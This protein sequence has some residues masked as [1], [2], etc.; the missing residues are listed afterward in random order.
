[1]PAICQQNGGG[2]KVGG[3]TFNVSIDRKA[4]GNEE[5]VRAYWFGIILSCFRTDG[6][7]LLFN[8]RTGETLILKRLTA[9]LCIALA[10]VFAVGSPSSAVDGIHHA[11]GASIEHGHLIFS[12]LAIEQ[13]YAD[14]NQAPDS[15]DTSPRDHLPGGH[16]HHGDSSSG[17]IAPVPAGAMVFALTSAPHGIEPERQTPGLKT[18]GPERPPKPLTMNA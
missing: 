1:M 7:L 12:D 14:C 2:I 8:V 6:R 11:K 5:L 15:D 17:M 3:E 4:L 16:H 13:D 10:L 9:M 18:R